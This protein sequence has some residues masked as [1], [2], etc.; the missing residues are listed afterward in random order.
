MTKVRKYNYIIY[1][2]FTV[3]ILGYIIIRVQC[4]E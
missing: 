1:N 2:D 4:I 3:V